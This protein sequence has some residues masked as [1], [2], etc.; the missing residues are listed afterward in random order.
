MRV[1]YE[2]DLAILLL[3]VLGVEKNAQL[4]FFNI[5]FQNPVVPYRELFDAEILL[6]RL[7]NGGAAHFVEVAVVQ[8]KLQDRHT[9]QDKLGN[10]LGSLN[11]QIISSHVEVLQVLVILDNSAHFSNLSSV[12]LALGDVQKLKL[13]IR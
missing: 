2:V 1:A 10:S 9:G 12:N 4:N 7:R 13:R 8:I 3:V 11:S 6:E 5:F